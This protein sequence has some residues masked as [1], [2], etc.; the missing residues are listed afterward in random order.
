MKPTLFSR[1]SIS[2]LILLSFN[3]SFAT[4]Y[5]AISSGSFNSTSTWQWGLIPPVTFSGN[6]TILIPSGITISSSS[7][8]TFSGSSADDRLIINGAL[9]MPNNTLRINHLRFNGDLG[10][11]VTTDSFGGDFTYGF[12]FVGDVNTRAMDGSGISV[13]Y[14]AQF[15]I[16]SLLYIKD[17][18][19]MSGKITIGDGALVILESNAVEPLPVL[20]LMPFSGLFDPIGYFD[21][22]YKGDKVYTS[23]EI[24][25][26]TK[27]ITIDMNSSQKQ[28]V[29]AMPFSGMS[30]SGKL[31]IKTG[32][33]VLNDRHLVFNDG[34]DCDVSTNGS[35]FSTKYS[36]I[37]IGRL[38]DWN[39][40]LKFAPGGDTVNTI[41]MYDHVVVKLASDL[42]VAGWIMLYKGRIDVQ[43]NTLKLMK[44]VTISGDNSS[45]YIITEGGG[46]L[47]VYLHPSPSA[48]RRGAYVP[49]GT[50]TSY[51]PMLIGTNLNNEYALARVFPGV[52][53]KAIAGPFWSAT[54]PVVNATWEVKGL[55]SSQN[56]YVEPS[57]FPSEEVN[58]FNIFNMAYISQYDSIGGWD[59]YKGQSVTS[60][61][62]GLWGLTGRSTDKVGYFAVFDMNTRLG[63]SNTAKQLN[64]ITYPNPTKDKLMIDGL[65][66]NNH[67][68][69]SDV[70]GKIVYQSS[71]HLSKLVIDMSSIAAGNYMLTITDD[72]NNATHQ[73]ITK[74]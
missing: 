31:N 29:F 22:I 73:K 24:G 18:L 5:T 48:P 50:S 41:T 42:S 9:S 70:S 66:G 44:D 20:R 8:I 67:I 59:N 43:N 52:R 3:K 58:G 74:E 23:I 51:M 32:M 27:S 65:K 47:S 61:S 56:L 16:D 40:T 1:L 12:H 19:E 26:R 25:S 17:S 33:L 28:V 54:R 2:L 45:N 46:Y 53:E 30:V 71:T 72:L 69:I 64:I 34:S 68:C 21:L 38:A 6:D 36:N 37:D 4:K 7:D 49:I 15:N 57:W 62:N 14:S 11:V 39:G 35:I 60:S 63:I 13:R 10:A 55:T